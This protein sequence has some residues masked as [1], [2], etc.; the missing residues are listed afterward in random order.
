MAANARYPDLP[1]DLQEGENV[2]NFRRRHWWFLWPRTVLWTLFAV[3]PVI[4][5]GWLATRYDLGPTGPFLAVAIVIWLVIWAV[6]LFLNWYAYQHDIWVVTNQRLVDSIKP[7]PFA[8]RVA[9][10]DLV[11]VQ[12]ITI[13]KTGI[14]PTFLN[15]GDVICQTAGEGQQFLISGI[16]DPESVQHLIDRERDRERKTYSD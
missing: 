4:V 14:L 3:V 10:A 1:F 6:R 7:N 15:F 2:L 5:I 11:N 13:S 12:D 8:L 16:P 9:T